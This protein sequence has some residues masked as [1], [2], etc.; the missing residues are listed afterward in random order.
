[1]PPDGRCGERDGRVGPSAVKVSVPTTWSFESTVSRGRCFVLILTRKLG[2]EIR[3]GDVVTVTVLDTVGKRVKL[4]ISGPPQIPV[5]RGEL[6]RKVQPKHTDSY[7]PRC[8]EN[9]TVP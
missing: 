3:I 6:A 4:G 5:L 2:E 1:M 8:P 7:H 9:S